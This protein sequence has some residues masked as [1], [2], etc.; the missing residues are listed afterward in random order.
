MYLDKRQPLLQNLKKQKEYFFF[1]VFLGPSPDHPSRPGVEPR[2]KCGAECSTTRPD[3]TS[4]TFTR[5]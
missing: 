1:E 3:G 4:H 2:S 5:K